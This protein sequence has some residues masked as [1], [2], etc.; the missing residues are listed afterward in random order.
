MAFGDDGTAAILLCRLLCSTLIRL[1]KCY[2]VVTR[3][4]LARLVTCLPLIIR[5]TRRALRLDGGGGGDVEGLIHKPYFRRE[6]I[7]LGMGKCVRRRR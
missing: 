3:L 6:F 4:Q 1:H 7:V 5:S 2:G